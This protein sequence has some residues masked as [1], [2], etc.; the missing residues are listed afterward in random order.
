[1]SEAPDKKSAWKTLHWWTLFIAALASIFG[2]TYWYR[3][4]LPA[5]VTIYGGPEDGRYDEL[6]RAVADQLHQRHK[7]RVKVVS[8]EGSLEN[9][10]ELKSGNAH[11]AFYQP[12]TREFLNPNASMP[13]SE[14]AS[15]VANVYTEVV[16]PFS[17]P[18]QA[19][20][21]FSQSEKNTTWGCS[22][23]KSG[24]YAATRVLFD[25]VGILVEDHK[26]ATVPYQKMVDQMQQGELDAGVIATGMHAPVLE[27]VFASPHC[28]PV[29]VPFTAALAHKHT[30][31]RET[32]IPAGFYQIHPPLPQTDFHT[33]GLRAQLL[34]NKETST[35]LVEAVTK[36]VTD[37]RFQRDNQLVELFAGGTE[38][39]VDGAEFALHAG[40]SNIYYPEFKPL[41]N[42]DFVEGTEGLRS[43]VV[44]IL[45]ATWLLYHWWTRRS[46][47]GNEHRLDRYIHQLL[48][49]ERR[50]LDFDAN[51]DSD[52]TSSLQ[53]LLDEVTM[54]RQEA[55][56]EFTA[57][58][59]NED[60]AADCFMH[61]CH[62]LSDKINAKLTRQTLI[63]LLRGEREG[64]G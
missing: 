9:L 21:I 37:A 6:A 61:M 43:F 7:I 5:E 30:S 4:R 11:F 19:E 59:L 8:S 39:A 42:P 64:D 26:I 47:L 46:I 57:H 22:G 12:R 53:D 27:Q 52:D 55:L 41:I 44:S 32:V 58:E 63:Q 62:A 36:I 17:T 50:Q 51:L 23:P 48:E 40:A 20:N 54:L 1:M 2:A 31:L 16:V 49:L 56:S 38:Y 18:S 24:D 14:P 45:F 28:R 35:R 60:S 13:T 34:T 15:F 3:T 25:H 29:E 33:V 10:K